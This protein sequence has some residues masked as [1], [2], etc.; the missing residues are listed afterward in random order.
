MEGYGNDNPGASRPLHGGCG[1][2]FD[3]G[4]FCCVRAVVGPA[5]GCGLKQLSI[6]KNQLCGLASS[7]LGPRIDKTIRIFAPVT[8]VL[9]ILEARTL[10]I[11][12]I[13]PGCGPPIAN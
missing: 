6:Q 5:Q 1:L 11:I 4:C 3:I 2:K 10:C 8:A 7:T 12:G 9:S 13:P